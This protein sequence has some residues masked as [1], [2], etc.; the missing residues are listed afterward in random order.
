MR[1]FACATLVATILAGLACVA[2]RDVVVLAK[3]AEHDVE[4]TAGN[5]W[6]AAD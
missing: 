6:E 2:R 4:T 1:R 5:L 3:D